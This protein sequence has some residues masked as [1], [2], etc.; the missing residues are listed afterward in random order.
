[1]RHAFG[2]FALAMGLS[3]SAHATGVTC[4][5]TSP[6]GSVISN[7]CVTQSQ[8]FANDPLDWSTVVNAFGP[9]APGPA[10]GFSN[11]VAVVL[12][13]SNNLVGADNTGYVWDGSEWT[14]PDFVAGQ[15]VNTFQ[16][17]F[18]APSAPSVPANYG[19]SLLGVVGGS[20]LS[21]NFLT[22][23]LSAGFRISSESMAN[24]TATMQAFDSSNN[25]LGTYSIAATG[26]GGVCAGLGVLNPNPSP[27]NDAPFLG[28]LGQKTPEISSLLVSTNDPS[29]MFLDTFYIQDSYQAV[30][31]PSVILLLGGGLCVIGLFRRKRIR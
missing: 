3:V 29:G 1:M 14:L 4:S 9:P 30:P 5:L 12:N 18:G 23:V 11:G 27:C 8:I 7:A 17:H 10:V 15:S 25:L 26:L 13:S 16:G 6:T 19:D 22:P 28:F 31:E 24:F 2:W 20:P 21:I